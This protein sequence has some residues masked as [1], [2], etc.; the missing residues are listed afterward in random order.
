MRSSPASE[1]SAKPEVRET[2]VGGAVVR[3]RVAGAGP[4][5]VCL[6]GLAGSSR[7]W[8]PVVPALT[9]RHEVHLL[10]LPGFGGLGRR[11]RR[12]PLAAAAG[13]LV[14]WADAAGL[15]RFDLAGHSMGAAIAVRVAAERPERIR[16]LVLVAPVGLHVRPL[17]G[18]GLPLAFTL[19]RSAP[20]LLWLLGRDAARAG[21][22][23]LVR[24][25]LEVVAD[26]VRADLRR[27][28]APTL[29]VCG[30]RDALVPASVG[31]IV[32]RERPL[33]ELV[34]LEGAAHVPMLER[35]AECA[36]ALVGFLE[37]EKRPDRSSRVPGT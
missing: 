17:A 32:R 4:P 11:S 28:A 18:H 29:V 35:P 8:A 25:T 10:D 22:R 14:D 1:R 13:W 31:E 33:A 36:E 15:A 3:H 2:R 6:H 20:R 37:G 9:E 21:P 23:T 7:W 19:R 5:V 27:V 24:A 26:D 16:R 30:G 12:V 34:V